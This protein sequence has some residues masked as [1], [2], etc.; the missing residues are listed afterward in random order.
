M[1][2][3]LPKPFKTSLEGLQKLSI[4][5]LVPIIAI[6]AFAILQIQS[7]NRSIEEIPLLIKDASRDLA[8]FQR[9]TDNLSNLK[10]NLKR[11]SER[12][13]ELLKV[14]DLR[15]RSSSY[16]D[17]LVSWRSK[18][19]LFRAQLK[20][21]LDQLQQI[22][23]KSNL[24]LNKLALLLKNLLLQEDTQ[25][26]SLQQFIEKQGDEAA[27]SDEMEILFQNYID[28]FLHTVR[29]LGAYRGSV[30]ELEKKLQA[31]TN[32][33]Y[34]KLKEIETDSEK[35]RNALQH[36]LILMIVSLALGIIAFCGVI[37]LRIRRERRS[38]ERRKTAR[39]VEHGRRKTD[40]L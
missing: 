7:T 8:A 24:Q 33:K 17:A 15:I 37:G 9:E 6:F 27:S 40:R 23:S 22:E 30:N 11:S 19:G 35:Y 1:P 31:L 12:H 10:V 5:L 32:A 26:I 29:A 36:Y 20:Q 4:I 39:N 34:L 28:E 25:W 13:L 3:N 18:A 21:D 38:R 14:V 2:L 16:Q